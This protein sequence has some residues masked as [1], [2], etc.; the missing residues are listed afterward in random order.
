MTGV[1]TCALPILQSYREHM[2]EF[3]QMKQLELWYY[4]IESTELIGNIKDAAIR[5]RAIRTIEKARASRIAEDVFPKLAGIDGDKM[6]IKDQLPTIFHWKGHKPGEIEQGIKAAFAD[7]R[8]TLT[9][10]HRLLLDRYELKDA[11]IKVVGVGS[12]GKRC[13]IMLFKAEN[14]DPLFLQV[15]QAGPSVME[16]YA[17]KSIIQHLVPTLPT[18]TTLIAA[19]FNSYR[20]SN[21]R[22]AGV[23]VWR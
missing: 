18:P 17:A 14:G 7:Y 12:V 13:W 2:L 22:C 20:S 16:P 4:L 11:A 21:R 6:F 23:S 19:S 3:S 9:P 15:K 5:K 1:Q 10:A 8:Q